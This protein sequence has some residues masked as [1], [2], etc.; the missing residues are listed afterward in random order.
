[1]SG[2][3][4]EL[5]AH[6]PLAD[7]RN[8]VQYF[9]VD[10]RRLLHPSRTP[11]V[12]FDLA[13]NP[14]LNC[15]LDCAYCYAR[16][17]SDKREAG[18]GRFAREVYAKREGPRLL[19]EEVLRLGRAG[20]A[21]KEV[22]LG[23]AT[24]PYQPYERRSKL[25][26]ALL[27]VLS[28]VEDLRLS[29]TTKSDLVLRDLDVLKGIARRGHVQVNLTVTTIDRDL[30]RSLEPRAPTPEKRLAAVRTLTR[31]GIP[32]G[33]FCMPVLPELTD[34]PRDLRAIVCAAR[35]AGARW[36]A[37]RVLFLKGEA[38]RAA[39]FE[40]LAR[41]RPDLVTKYQRLYRGTS[42]PD[43]IIDRVDR[44]VDAL[45]QQYRLPEEQAWPPLKEGPVQLS[46]FEQPAPEPRAARPL[47]V[48]AEEEV[49]SA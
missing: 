29:I 30:A 38:V 25:T 33:V 43:A 24:D 40:W 3:W 23:T 36:F 17:F 46:L 35:E 20:L 47:P 10:T 6:A 15:E 16:E 12:P 41:A 39:F 42:A 44:L 34:A 7:E 22:A 21:G 37:A 9:E 31:A 48:V 4:Q 1:M 27:E 28:T 18:R 2:G 49:E 32:A 45:R 8:D 19:R 26:R 5:L 14:Y 11:G 13:L